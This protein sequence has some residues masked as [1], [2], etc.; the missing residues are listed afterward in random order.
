MARDR[1]QDFRGKMRTRRYRGHSDSDKPTFSNSKN[2]ICHLCREAHFVRDCLHLDISAEA[3]E[4][5]LEK[6]R[7]ELKYSK[8]GRETSSKLH[9]ERSKNKTP[10]KFEKKSRKIPSKKSRA[11]AAQS[12]DSSESLS[13]EIDKES[14]DIESV[15]LSASDI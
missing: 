11:Y 7:N 15:A 2:R 3:V 13:K 12:S 5:Y 1:N 6:T 14:T 4:E 10:L 8:K 9:S